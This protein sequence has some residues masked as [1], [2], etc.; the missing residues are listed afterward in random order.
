MQG[1]KDAR[2]KGRDHRHRDGSRR[3]GSH[4]GFQPCHGVKDRHGIEGSGSRQC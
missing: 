4:V 1:H 2:I 3:F